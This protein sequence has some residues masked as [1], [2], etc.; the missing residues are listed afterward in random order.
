MRHIRKC[1]ALPA[2]LATLLALAAALAPCASAD[3][4]GSVHFVRS[5]DSAFDRYT[6]DP[7]P[8]AQEWLRTHMWR[9]T[10]FSPYFDEKTSWF[11]NG[12]VYDDA[13]AIYSGEQLVSQ[14]PDWILKDAAGNKLYIPFGCSSGSCPQYA[15]DISNPAFRQYWIENL[16]DELAHGYR[17]VFIDDVNMEMRVGTGSEQHVA[18]IDPS[19]GQPMSEEDWRHYM[20]TFMQEVRAALPGI[21][22]VH[23]VIWFADEHAG[24]SDPDIRSELSS[25]DLINLERGANDSGLTG[26]GGPWSLNALLAYVDEIHA[27]GR[28]VVMDGNKGDPHSLEYDLAA[29]FLISDGNDAVS[30][31]EQT[32]ENWWTGWS[33]NLGE[34]AGPRYSW[35]GLLRRDFTGGMVLLNG[36]G[37]PTRTVTLPGAM[38]EIDGSAVESVTL[39]ASGAVILKGNAIPNSPSSPPPRPTQ[40]IVEP[41]V[42]GSTTASAPPPGRGLAASQRHS[43]ARSGRVTR[44]TPPRVKMMLARID[45]RVLRATRGLVTIVVELRR[46]H[47]WVE[48]RRA[49]TALD[50][51]GQFG[52][53]LGLR[54][55]RHYRVLALY[56]GAPGYRPSRSRY[57]QIVPR[58]Q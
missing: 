49:A 55:G 8:E 5:A 7:S 47:R 14:H 37:E 15:G 41:R 3:P 13:Y 46:G 34:A 18:P 33:T 27:L 52:L 17:G 50:S 4:A 57:R 40:T 20:A 30:G 25:A 23:N 53:P 2:L 45:G 56:R 26:G 51:R 31:A 10:V 42:V 35:Q 58:R 1:T 9:M 12:W 38:R 29:Y 48:V 6:S 44:A 39:G 36:P 21:E 22:I 11:P 43:Q 16:K 19:T 32:P 54:A 28:G 24:S